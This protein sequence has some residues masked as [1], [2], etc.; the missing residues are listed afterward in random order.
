MWDDVDVAGGDVR[1]QQVDGDGG[2]VIASLLRE[3]LLT[4]EGDP[5]TFRLAL[6]RREEVTRWFGDATGWKV[7]TSAADGLCR[8]YKRRRDP[9]RDRA[10]RLIRR[11]RSARRPASPLVLTLLCLVCEQLWRHPETGFNDLQLE[12]VQSCATEADTSRLPRFQPVA[13]AGREHA[14]AN[15]H[16]TAL[17][18]ALRLLERWR[19]AAVDRPLDVAEQ[20]D[21]ADLLITAR[22]DRLAAL[23]ACHPPGLLEVDLDQPDTHVS[24]LCSDQ[25]P[26]PEHASTRQHD[27]RRRHVAV[28]SVLDDPGTDPETDGE[29]GGYLASTA[30]GRYALDAAA[31][32]G[33]CCTVRRDWWIVADPA[34]ATTDLDFPHGR[35]QEQQAAMLLLSE[36]ARRGDPTAAVTKAQVTAL[37]R[38][39][40]DRRPWWAGRYRSP[41]GA[42]RLAER[43]LQ[44]LTDAGVV[45]PS[46]M[47]PD[48]V[49]PTPAVRVWVLRIIDPHSDP[50]P[51]DENPGNGK[52][53]CDG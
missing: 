5:D 1:G 40:L 19:V 12:I 31:A 48:V 32:A 52:G 11:E 50:D 26:L 41:R 51:A 25:A 15:T 16:R 3:P 39:H 17:V 13:P 2:Q 10:P 6:Y 45:H 49:T 30:G 38:V 18:D 47:T 53:C 23:L 7:E 37:M 8:L 21:H 9:P 22:R 46:G 20:D 43:A 42:E 24:L 4:I 28:R 44:H 36:L 14:R 33:L 27:L 34:G 35:S 29:A